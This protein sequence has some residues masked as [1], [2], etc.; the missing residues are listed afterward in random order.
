LNCVSSQTSLQRYRHID[1]PHNYYNFSVIF[2]V[3]YILS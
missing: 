3:Y 2:T 1:L